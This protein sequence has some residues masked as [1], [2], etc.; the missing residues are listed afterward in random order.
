MK[1]NLIYVQVI[2]YI[3]PL[4][5]EQVVM[6]LAVVVMAVVVMADRLLL[7]TKVGV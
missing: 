2:H 3:L 7:R 4:D 1:A 6:I 5:S